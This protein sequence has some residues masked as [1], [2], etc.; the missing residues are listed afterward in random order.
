M[1]KAQREKRQEDYSKLLEELK[2][3]TEKES[4]TTSPLLVEGDI[5][6]VASE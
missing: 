4:T 1:L 6:L 2:A 3:R 5:K